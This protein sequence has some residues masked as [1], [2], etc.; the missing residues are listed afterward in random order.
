MTYGE[1]ALIGLSFVFSVVVTNCD[2]RNEY[3]PLKIVGSQPARKYRLSRFMKLM[4]QSNTV[5]RALPS[6]KR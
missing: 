4:I 3:E 6:K 5:P 1:F 2:A